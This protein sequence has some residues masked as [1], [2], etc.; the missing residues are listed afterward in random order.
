VSTRELSSS[1]SLRRL[2][3][4]AVG[5]AALPLVRKL[6]GIGGGAGEL[7]DEELLLRAAVID[8]ERLAEYCRVCTFQI[9]DAVPATYPHL[10]AFPLSMQLM[11][12]TS[13]P[14]PLMGLVHV[15]NRIEQRRPIRVADQLDIRVR[16]ADL[17]PHSK[18]RQ[19]DVLAE[20]QVEGETVWASKSTY[21]RRGGGSGDSSGDKGDRPQP[22]PPDTQ[23]TVPGDIGRRYASVSGD[24]NPIHLHPLSARFFGM[25]R[26]IAHGMWLKA[27]CLAMLEGTL[28]DAFSVEVAFKL[29]VPLPSKVSFASDRGKF[30]LHDAKNEKPH[31][32]GTVTD[33]QG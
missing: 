18:G 17:R 1:P 28:P 29:P 23:L 27:R 11:T 3:P 15:E 32:G 22:P 10:L 31:L 25:P 5:G 7:P 14:F 21:L 33:E 24:R 9:G 6:P 8:Q 20:A 26:P 4:K 12:D 13:F 30:S 16:T 19:F 2:Y